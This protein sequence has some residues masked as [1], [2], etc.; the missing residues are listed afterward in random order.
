MAEGEYTVSYLRIVTGLLLMAMSVS[1]TLGDT[2]ATSGSNTCKS[3]L[4]P[5]T[6]TGVGLPLPGEP[7]DIWNFLQAHDGRW[8]YLD[9]VHVGAF[10]EFIGKPTRG[11]GAFRAMK[12]YQYE[13]GLMLCASEDIPALSMKQHDRFAHVDPGGQVTPLVSDP[14]IA[15]KLSSM[16]RRWPVSLQDGRPRALEPGEILFSPTPNYS[17]DGDLPLAGNTGWIMPG[18][19]GVLFVPKEGDTRPEN[20]L[21]VV[22]EAQGGFKL[23][24]GGPTRGGELMMA[25]AKS[26]EVTLGENTPYSLESRRGGTKRWDL[27]RDREPAMIPPGFGMFPPLDGEMMSRW[28]LEDG[29]IHLDAVR[30]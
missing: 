15:A 1:S 7:W 25:V 10:G 30:Y 20:V 13:D 22:P 17:T 27:W 21:W 8:E 18:I 19:E 16:P 2:G 23:V 12:V 26:G 28:T 11:I 4:P 6:S 14:A 24:W 9:D 29:E 3:L 5:A